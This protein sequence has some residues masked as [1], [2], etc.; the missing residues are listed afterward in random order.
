MI[1][2]S[3]HIELQIFINTLPYNTTLCKMLLY[4]IVSF[5]ISYIQYDT[6]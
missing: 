2:I 1:I 3:I 5:D 6:V 4:K